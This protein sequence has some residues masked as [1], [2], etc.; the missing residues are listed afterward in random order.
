MCQGRR[1]Q[2]RVQTP[3]PATRKV[4]EFEPHGQWHA[5]G[6]KAYSGGK[7]LV[8]SVLGVGG[9]SPPGDLLCLARHPR[10]AH[11]CL[12]AYRTSWNRQLIRFYHEFYFEQS[13]KLQEQYNSFPLN[14]LIVSWLRNIISCP[15]PIRQ[16]LFPKNKNT[17]LQEHNT[18]MKICKFT[19]FH[20]NC[21]LLR[22]HSSVIHHQRVHDSRRALLSIPWWPITLVSPSP[23]QLAPQ[24]FLDFSDVDAFGDYKPVT[25]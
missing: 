11:V 14:R 7:V 8:L 9:F 15:L 13:Q 24:A 19:S 16:W 2:G 4:R 10:S 20:F 18:P 6:R 25:L 17:L 22:P 3:Q 5:K 23:H 1:A 12:T 21:L